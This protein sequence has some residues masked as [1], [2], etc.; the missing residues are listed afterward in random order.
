MKII[1]ARPIMADT[2]SLEE[3]IRDARA[4][5]REVSTINRRTRL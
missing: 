5:A 4:A 3:R 2:R 1:N